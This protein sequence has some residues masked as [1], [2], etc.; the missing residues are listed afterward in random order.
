MNRNILIFIV[1]I[2]LFYKFKSK[3]KYFTTWCNSLDNLKTNNTL[4]VHYPQND[5]DIFNLLIKCKNENKKLRVSGATHSAP[6]IVT[7]GTDD[8]III[9]LHNYSPPITWDTFEN[10]KIRI[11]AG[12]T[13]LD[14]YSKTRPFNYFLPTQTAGFFF[15]I[16]GVFSTSVHGSVFG[17]G[18]VNKY[19]TKIR[20]IEFSDEEPKIREI[21][22][23]AELNLWRCGYGFL[24]IL[25]AVEFEMIKIPNFN[26]NFVEESIVWNKDNLNKLITKSKSNYIGSDFFIDFRT[27]NPSVY[28]VVFEKTNVNN[29]SAKLQTYQH[30]YDKYKTEWN[31]IGLKGDK[32]ITLLNNIFKVFPFIANQR[33]TNNLIMDL[34]KTRL[35]SYAETCQNELNDGF[36]VKESPCVVLMAY[37]CPIEYGFEFLDIYRNVFQRRW[38][39]KEYKLNQ[40]CEFRCV[41]FDDNKPFLY[42]IPNG[43]YIVCEVIAIKSDN[44]FMYECF[45]EIEYLW[46]K[47]PV[48]IYPHIAKTWAFNNQYKP[49]QKENFNLYKNKLITKENLL[50]FNKL[51]SIRDPNNIFY[52]SMSSWLLEN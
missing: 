50:Y 7:D 52:T 27:N 42:D 17:A 29:N 34:T 9:S 6:G 47:I 40:F 11:S 51:R 13:F 3:P 48:N 36:W 23:T 49:F 43:E 8:Q 45:Y 38:L 25:T 4:I 5:Q 1:F 32:K 46:K 22:D 21:D 41:T 30:L 28:Q 2:I 14:L 24:G 12:K 20:A 15:T 33:F 39:S 18:M 35:K 44:N 31:E 10:N 19:V 16:G 26:V 37:Y